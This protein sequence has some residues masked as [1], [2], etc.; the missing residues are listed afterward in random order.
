MDT[1]RCH[2]VWLDHLRNDQ[3]FRVESKKQTTYYTL[4]AAIIYIIAMSSVYFSLAWIGA[5]SASSLP[6]T[7]TN[8]GSV[9]TYFTQQSFGIFGNIML[10][11]T[12]ALAC[13][14]TNVG[15]TAT[16]SEYFTKRFQH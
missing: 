12:M 6:E 1:F 5:S 14:T 3:I 4:I 2:W 11:T 13:L 9:L 15:L 7:V 16:A 8:G 10:G